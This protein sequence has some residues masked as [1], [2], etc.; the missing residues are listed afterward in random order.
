MVVPANFTDGAT[1]FFSPPEIA[2]DT[3][4]AVMGFLAYTN[5]LIID[6]RYNTGGENY[7]AHMLASYMVEADPIL[8]S[9]YCEKE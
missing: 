3:A 1:S 6:L 4:V 9:T 8:C 2:D 7:M 5:A